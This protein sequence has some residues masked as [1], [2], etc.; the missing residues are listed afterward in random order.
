[1]K[2]KTLRTKIIAVVLSVLM[3]VPMFAVNA[4]AAENVEYNPTWHYR[5]YVA[6]GVTFHSYCESYGARTVSNKR[7]EAYSY[8]V[9]DDEN[10][11]MNVAWYITARNCYIGITDRDETSGYA[12]M[13]EGD[14]LYSS[15]ISINYDMSNIGLLQRIF[16]YFDYNIGETSV[17]PN[18]GE[19][20]HT[21]TKYIVDDFLIYGYE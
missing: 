19:I 1:M 6:G 18:Y 10:V 4:M 7:Q 13:D 20:R 17:A 16:T 2:K 9:M 5:T 11:S 8:L 15:T 21:C 14:S 12:W 3:L